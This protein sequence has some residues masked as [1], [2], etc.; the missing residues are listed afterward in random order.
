MEGSSAPEKDRFT[1][2]DTLALARELR[3]L[4]P[5][6][7]DKVFDDTTGAGT[8]VQFRVPGEGRR[9]L[10]VV[11]GRYAA[12]LPKGGE[13]SEEPGPFARELRR[14]LTG[15]AIA[16]IADPG[17]ERYLEVSFRRGDV[18]EPLA[19]ALELFGSGNIVVARDGRVVAV[20]HP[21][22]WAHRTLR[23]GADYRAPPARADPWKLGAAEIASALLA[24]HADRARTLAARLAFGGPVAE[25][26]LAR[27][28]LA[29][30]AP[31]AEESPAVSERLHQEL[32]RLLAELGDRPRGYLYRSDGVLLDV[33]PFRSTRWAHAPKTSVEE[34]ATF[35]EAAEAYFAEFRPVAPSAAPVD[36]RQEELRRH[37]AQQQAALERLGS[38]AEA[39]RAQADAILVYYPEAEAALK[40]ATEDSGAVEL[41]LG[42]T[43][44]SLPVGR[45]PRER[46]QELYDAMKSVQEKLAGA[47]A[48][49]RA[50]ERELAAPA[51]SAPRAAAKSAGTAARRRFWFEA[52]RWFLSSEG[53][54][55][56]G[57][58]DAGSNDRIVKRYLGAGDRYVH[59]DLHGAPS[60]VV[61]HP[62]PGSPEMGEATLREA[63][64]WGL[65]Y[66]KAWRAGRGS[67]D[68]FWVEAEQVS[69]TPA[70]GE[71]VAR[72]AWVIHGTKHVLHDLPLEL[73][74]G[75]VVYEGTELWCAAPRESFARGGRLRGVLTPGEERDRP[76]V[77]RNLVGELGISREEVQRLLPPGGVSFRRA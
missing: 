74:L 43:P 6:R 8:I 7:V 49:L 1:S 60:V 16:G 58:R 44:V 72:G 67:G 62:P 11:P 42:G 27:A 26:L 76:E 29:G 30:E 56:I 57:G 53:V 65:A 37:L 35:S 4:G 12:L 45:S 3:A 75:T 40:A 34:F 32:S 47:R 19:L 23:I 39:F 77:E 61:K 66:S 9:E 63:C 55:A 41:E 24:S 18:A 50:T 22:A 36:A 21:R 69:K 20:L 14:L 71:F 15:A 33:E 68:A 54:L 48:A 70:S 38:E 51:S 17:G 52:Y 46:A 59:A 25:E 5:A 73:G 64:Q 28:G 13:H 2:L 31:A 10:H